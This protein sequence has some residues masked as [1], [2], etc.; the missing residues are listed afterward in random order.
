[1]RWKYD[2]NKVVSDDNQYAHVFSP[3]FIQI[4]FP[5]YFFITYANAYT[6]A[7]TGKQFALGD[8]EL[9]SY[10]RHLAYNFFPGL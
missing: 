10:K 2:L 6:W 4:I 1:M 3:R 5:K 9:F 7:R 8:K